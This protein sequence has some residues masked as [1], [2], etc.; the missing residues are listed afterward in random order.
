MGLYAKIYE[1]FRVHPIAMKLAQTGGT[2][3]HSSAS[4][5]CGS[6][7]WMGETVDGIGPISLQSGGNCSGLHL[8][9]GVSMQVLWGR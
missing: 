7:I 3:L 4:G 2:K 5:G 1:N 9:K 8:K 6:M